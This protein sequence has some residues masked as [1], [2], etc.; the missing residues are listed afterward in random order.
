MGDLS[1]IVND[2]NISCAALN[3]FEAN[4]VLHI[5]TDTVLPKAI[6]F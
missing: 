2:F 3:P 1:V 6:A 5:D 4:S